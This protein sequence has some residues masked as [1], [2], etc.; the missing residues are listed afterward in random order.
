[1]CFTKVWSWC[2]FPK[3]Q[4]HLAKHC[5]IWLNPLTPG[6]WKTPERLIYTLTFS[7]RNVPKLHCKFPFIFKTEK[8]SENWREI[9]FSVRHANVMQT[10]VPRVL[11]QGAERDMIKRLICFL[12]ILKFIEYWL[13]LSVKLI[14]LYFWFSSLESIDGGNR[15]PHSVRVLFVVT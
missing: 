5:F 4:A 1:M 7:G 3:A 13:S 2:P 11:R 12:V 14:F 6:A 10:S 15:A 9:K 8:V